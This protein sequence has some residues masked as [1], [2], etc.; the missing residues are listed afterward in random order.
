MVWV[1]IIYGVALMVTGLFGYFKSD[2]VSVTALIPAFLG[3]PVLIFSLLGRNPKFLKT[4]MHI[5]VLIALMGFL[6]TAKD[7]VG[8]ISGDDFENP[9]AG[10]SKSITCVLSLIFII[11]AVNSFIQ[12]RKTKSLKNESSG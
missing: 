5:N 10:Y 1:G 6:A 9:L 7:T 12:V 8:L 3:T 4:G 2:A 11:L